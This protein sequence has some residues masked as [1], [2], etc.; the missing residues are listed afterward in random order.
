MDN[1]MRCQ[2]CGHVEGEIN[3]EATINAKWLCKKCYALYR[4]ELVS[5]ADRFVG[6]AHFEK[7]CNEILDGLRAMG[8]EP[9]EENFRNTPK[10]MARAYSE[11]FEGVTNRDKKIA[12]IL[13]TSFPAEGHND[14]VV[15]SGIVAYSMCPHHLLP[16]EYRVAVGYIP[17]PDGRVIGISKIARIVE[18]LSKQPALQEA[19]TQQI[20]SAME[21]LNPMGVGVIVLGRHL[22]MRM[23]GV[24]AQHG[25]IRTS[26]V[27]GVFKDAAPRAEF[28]SL[29]GAKEMEF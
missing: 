27:S 16:V 18:V 8:F 15:A 14:M 13:S 12:D 9:D 23:R 10:R 7:A 1:G 29:I 2:R 5:M 3:T 24:K 4:E 22:C 21:T 11:I 20:R 6:E 28:M 25:A 19:Y 17:S 26:A